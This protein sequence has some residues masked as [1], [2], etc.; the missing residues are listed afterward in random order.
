MTPGAMPPGPSLP[1]VWIRG[2]YHRTCPYRKDDIRA[3]AK[4]KTRGSQTNMFYAM[5]C[6]MARYFTVYS[7]EPRIELES[8]TKIVCQNTSS[9]TGKRRVKHLC[10]KP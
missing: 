9:L 10:Y 7:I 8:V 6:C 3:K 5:K 1:R 4:A 2:C